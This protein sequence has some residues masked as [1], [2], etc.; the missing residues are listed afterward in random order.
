MTS[1][2]RPVTPDARTGAHQCPACAAAVGRH[3]RFCE[4]CGMH[5]LVH[6]T[7]VGGPTAA[8]GPH[9][10]CVY[11]TNVGVAAD[12]FCAH[13]GRAQPPARD[14][15]VY[16]LGLV[17][18]V[19]DRGRR[20][21]RN[22][23]ALAFAW[24]GRQTAPQGVVATVCDGV[25]SSPRAAD[26]AQLAADTGVDTLVSDLFA[27]SGRD[28]SSDPAAAV[29]SAGAAAGAAVAELAAG[30]G[31]PATTYV[32]AVVTDSDVTVGWAGDSRA[33]W[34]PANQ[35]PTRRLT[36]DHTD[37]GDE[38]GALARWLGADADDPT[39][40]VHT[41]RPP[42]AGTVLLCS[43]GLWGYVPDPAWLAPPGPALSIAE[44]LT[45]AAIERGGRDN[46]AVVVIGFPF[47]AAPGGQH[48]G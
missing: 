17:A 43:D 34:L 11:C 26:A 20:R 48:A 45:A 13:C 21:Q 37:S 15:A 1:L 32:S 3:D 42:S 39:V 2:H 22:E 10:R 47:A 27:A 38:A 41:F 36:V 40:A 5:L 18:G 12:Q 19:T 29:G 16:D 8:T 30:D 33:Y 6:R 44:T 31:A 9:A 28:G 46:I 14:R 35:D 7:P 23:D 25:A 4:G 24:I